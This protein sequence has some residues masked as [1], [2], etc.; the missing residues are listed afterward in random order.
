[1]TDLN[2]IEEAI[3]EAFKLADIVKR[4]GETKEIFQAATESI[5][6]Y[7]LNVCNFVLLLTKTE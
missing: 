5:C 6:H 2:S 7:G 1:M 3:R 4:C